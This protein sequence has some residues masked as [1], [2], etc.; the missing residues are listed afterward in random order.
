MGF[1]TE[2]YKPVVLGV[3]ATYNFPQGAQNIGGFLC[4]TAGTITVVN[5]AGTTIVNALPVSAGVYYPMPFY[6]SSGSSGSVTLSGGSS[7]DRTSV[8][9]GRGGSVRVDLGGRRNI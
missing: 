4:V 7:G 3:N 9:W 5:Q 6:L 1:I 8:G 2:R